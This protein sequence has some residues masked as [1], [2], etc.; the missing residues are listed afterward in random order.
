M[1][2][3]SETRKSISVTMPNVA[4]FTI[5]YKNEDDLK[6]QIC[7]KLAIEPEFTKLIFIEKDEEQPTI[8]AEDLDDFEEEDKE[9]ERMV[10]VDYI[11]AR[12]M[13]ALGDK[14]KR[15]RDAKA[16]VVGAGALCNEILKNLVWIGFGKILIVPVFTLSA[17]FLLCFCWLLAIHA[18]FLNCLKVYKRVI[19]FNFRQF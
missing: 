4:T 19:G 5:N 6:S 2:N 13:I 3:E 16:L 9:P 17:F 11:W 12:Q 15:L 18:P 1:E 14:Q 8:S 10:L 7:E